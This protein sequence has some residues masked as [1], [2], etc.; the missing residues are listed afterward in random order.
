M[1]YVVSCMR[2]V[3]GGRDEA[4][5]VRKMTKASQVISGGIELA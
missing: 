3:W 1:S 2:E 4:D 5:A